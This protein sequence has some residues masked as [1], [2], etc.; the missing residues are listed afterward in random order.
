MKVFISLIVSALISVAAAHAEIYRWVDE[1]GNTHFG[2]KPPSTKGES[3]N[4][5]DYDQVNLR[6]S[7][8]FSSV[9]QKIPIPYR[10][11][12]KSRLILFEELHVKLRRSERHD[13]EIGTYTKTVGSLCGSPE[14]IVWTAGYKNISE[15]GLMSDVIV[16]F[17]KQNY[18]MITGNIFSVSNSASR[19]VLKA[20]VTRLRLDYCETIKRY[21]GIKGYEK[22]SVYMKIKWELSDRITKQKLFSGSSQGAVNAF[23]QFRKDG[24]TEAITGAIHMAAKNLLAKKNFVE[25]LTPTADDKK[26]QQAVIY[27]Q[28]KL[29]IQYGDAKT[30]FK[31]RVKNLKKSAVTIRVEEGHGSG[32]ILDQSGYIL[33]NAHVVGDAENVVVLS[34]NL[35]IPGK[36]VRRETLRDVALIKVK[37]LS[38]TEGAVISKNR[39][40]EGDTI[41]VIG[42]PLD[43]SLSNT[44]T[45]GIYSAHRQ[46]NGLS[47]YQT[48]AAVNPGNSGG[49]VFDEKGE[50]IAISVAGVFT[51]TGAS[52]NV[53][54][55]IPI[56]SAL[57]FLNVEKERDVSHIM[58]VSGKSEDE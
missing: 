33:T 8:I 37:K 50:L 7:R 44:I 41:Y 18:R 12:E 19:L 4:T 26:H 43:E 5:P 45:K 25:H 17:K 22:A 2:D 13:L 9:K 3:E 6:S 52:L 32:V 30:S 16:A 24:V 54:Y 1:Q 58:D 48:D 27:S 14:R 31:Q 35:E 46:H 47:Y 39:P 23:D 51:R 55:L 28:M 53:N 42:T 57:K 29:G 38:N 21:S 34:G 36:V 11:T 10:G 20:T 40:T 49:P 15:S 56:E